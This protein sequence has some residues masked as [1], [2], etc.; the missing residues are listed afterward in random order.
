MNRVNAV[1]Y[2]LL[3][4]L[5][6]YRSIAPKHVHY[7][8]AN[9]LFISPANNEGWEVTWNDG[10][11]RDSTF[12]AKEDLPLYIRGD[13]EKRDTFDADRKNDTVI[14]FIQKAY[15]KSDINVSRKKDLNLNKYIQL[16]SIPVFFIIL[17]FLGTHEISLLLHLLIFLFISFLNVN[18][19]FLTVIAAAFAFH[20]PLYGVIGGFLVLLLNLLNPNPSYRVP[21]ILLSISTIIVAI[22]NEINFG[23]AVSLDTL[24]IAIA[25]ASFSMLAVN[26]FVKSFHQPD[27]IIL[28]SFTLFFIL[29]GDNLSGAVT[30]VYQAFLMIVPKV[31]NQLGHKS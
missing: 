15:G 26:W 12:I 23:T 31:I 16:S 5:W 20:G 18:F 14:S 30:L 17:H 19:F 1:R 24:G 28:P 2:F 27:F 10:E 4:H 29:N 9:S 22:F 3:K 25:A 13:V 6:A 21:L 7:N 11:K 8:I